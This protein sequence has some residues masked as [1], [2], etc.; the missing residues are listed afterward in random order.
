MK[1]LTI[2]VYGA[3]S[4]DIDKIYIDAA[5]ALG[6][7][8]AKRQ[9]NLIYG[10][11]SSG[12]MGGCSAGVLE[13]GGKVIGVVPSFMNRFEAIEHNCTQ[14]LRTRTM[15]LRKDVM[16]E[17]CDAFIITPGGIGTFDEFFQVL[18]QKELGQLDKP[19]VIFNVNHFYDDTIALIR[20][21]IS[22]GFVRP[23]VMSI[24]DVCE[25][26]IDALNSIEQ[27]FA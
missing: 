10:G 26:E 21:L 1:K 7:E 12:L 13:N 5:R 14:L 25:N 4:S 6:E 11:G 2:C 19:I 22:M 9:Y 3:A 15:S 18:T 16:E 8:I 17:N 24:F 23:S 27:F 20:K